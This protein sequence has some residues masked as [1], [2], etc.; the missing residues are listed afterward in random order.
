MQ[1]LSQR[2]QFVVAVVQAEVE[3]GAMNKDQIVRG[4]QGTVLMT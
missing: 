4:I 2:V 3:V 1:H